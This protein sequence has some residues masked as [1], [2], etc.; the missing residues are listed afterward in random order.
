VARN[1]ER[2][3]VEAFDGTTIARRPPSVRVGVER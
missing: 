2:A 1:R 3:S